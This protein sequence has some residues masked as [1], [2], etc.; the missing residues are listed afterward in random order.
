[1]N[2]YECDILKILMEESFIS[3]RALSDRLGCSLGVVNRSL[4]S[5]VKNHD[6]DQ[7]MQLTQKAIKKIQSS[8]PQKAI[9]LAAGYGMRMIPINFNMPKGLLKIKGETLI[10]RMIQQLHE[11]GIYDISV[12]VG[13]MKECYEYLIDEYQV[14]LIYNGEYASKNLSLIHI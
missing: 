13:F 10:E 7:H 12:V 14:K 1:M 9:I 3:Q 11:V 5:L 2:K 8:S 4:Q 6:L